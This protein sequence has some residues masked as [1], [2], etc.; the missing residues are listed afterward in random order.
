[1][2]GSAANVDAIVKTASET[3]ASADKIKK[4][5]TDHTHK[6]LLDADQDLAEDFQANGTPHFF[7]NGRRVVGAQPEEKFDK[8]ID[9]EIKKAQDLIAKGT[10]PSEVYE[11]LVKDGKGPPEPEK[12][13]MPKSLP[14]N[15]PARGNLSAR[16]TIH[17]WSDFQ[18]PFCGRV[19]PTV[20]QVM[21]EY[22]DRVKFVWH[23]LPLPMHPDAPLA[24]QAGREAYAQKGP[25]AFWQMH[26]KMFANQQKLKRDDLDA[27]AKDLNLNMD[28]WK[29]A[30]DGSSHTS[31]I[32]A[33][34]K[35][36]ND[37]GISGTPAFIIVSGNSTSGYFVNGAQ[38]Y[39]KFRKLIEMALS[40]SK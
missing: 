29:S 7:V 10:K 18:C 3:G 8:V 36:G 32:D 14:S 21:K 27:Y 22:G 2:N 34:K 31:E 26:D 28:K 33:D 40:N 16:V 6:K 37:D 30:L 20:A 24:A 5:I 19:E 38:S 25:S 39:G 17:E 35:A 12:K 4:A 15:D 13:D 1:M 23:D 11:A 9:E